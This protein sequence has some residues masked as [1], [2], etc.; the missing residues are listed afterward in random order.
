MMGKGHQ[1]SFES[2][3]APSRTMPD[4]V[5]TIPCPI[6]L[7]HAAVTRRAGDRALS[8]QASPAPG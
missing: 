7:R 4:D 5:K 1:P 2:F 8:W 6:N 3:A